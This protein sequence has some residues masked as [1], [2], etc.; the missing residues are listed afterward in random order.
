MPRA[1]QGFAMAIR[2]N[3]P[4]EIG[5]G[6]SSASSQN[7]N[8]PHV[9]QQKTEW[10]WVACTK[11]VLTVFEQDVDQCKIASILFP[12]DGCCQSLNDETTCNGGCDKEDILKV[13]NKFGVTATFIDDTVSFPTIRRRIRDQKTPVQVCINWDEGGAHVLVIFGWRVSGSKR[14]LRIHD[15]LNHGFG[16]IRFSELGRYLGQGD[17]TMTWLDFDGN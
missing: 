17:W 9:E 12:S 8:I 15:S 5:S 1:S 11:M 4:F 13:Y 3:T 2:T 6:P 10:C 16:E 14:Y 7:L